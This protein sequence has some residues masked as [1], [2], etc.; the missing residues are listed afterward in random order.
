PAWE[1]SDQRRESVD[2][3]AALAG[4][5]G[6]GEL[7]GVP[8]DEGFSFRRDAEVLVGAGTRLADVGLSTLDQQPVAFTP[9]TAGEVAA[10]DDAP[11][12]EPGPA[13]AV[14]HGQRRQDG[15]EIL[16]GDCEQARTALAE[17]PA[18][19][20]EVVARGRE[21]VVVSAPLE[22]GRRR[23]APEPFELPE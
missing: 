13:E 2:L 22:L 5:L 20:E 4:G 6:P 1:G 23:D 10:G 18:D 7:A 11:N 19:R 16:G 17:G 21:L 15:V 14:A 8:F 9:R 3:D 12:G